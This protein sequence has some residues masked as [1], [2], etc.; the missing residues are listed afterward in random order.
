MT[1]SSKLSYHYAATQVFFHWMLIPI[2][3]YRTIF[4][5]LHK[6]VIAIQ[7]F[8]YPLRFVWQTFI[9][10]EIF[11]YKYMAIVIAKR[12]L[13]IVDDFFGT[14]FFFANMVIGLVAAIAYNF[15]Q[16]SYEMQSAFSGYPRVIVTKSPIGNE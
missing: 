11:V 16:D 12:V 14:Y 1:I 13:P 15:T 10:I 4:G 2:L 8:I 7:L 9:G 5:P 6:W 3:F